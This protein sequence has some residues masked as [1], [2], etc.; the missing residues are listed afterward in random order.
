MSNVLFLWPPS[1]LS[2]RGVLLSRFHFFFRA[3]GDKFRFIQRVAPAYL[4]S[5]DFYF[6][7]QAEG[8][9]FFFFSPPSLLD[10]I[11]SFSPEYS[12]VLLR[13]FSFSFLRLVRGAKQTPFLP[14]IWPAI[15]Y[16]PPALLL[17][18][19]PS[20]T[21]P[22]LPFPRNRGTFFYQKSGDSSSSP[23][24]RTGVPPCPQVTHPLFRP[25]S[26]HL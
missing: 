5:I 18:L 7:R 1:S 12:V 8:N 25:S 3:E 16:A 20:W 19:P 9:L 23:P 14:L 4:P 21:A 13:C 6:C 15:S 2:P 26:A 22:F 24:S 11:F 17:V 10:V